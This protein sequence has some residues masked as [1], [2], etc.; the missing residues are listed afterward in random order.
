[1]SSLQ[2]TVAGVSAGG[3]SFD[4]RIYAIYS[5]LTRKLHFIL[6]IPGP[7]LWK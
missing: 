3:H 2:A 1:M 5:T 7:Q 6:D 4:I